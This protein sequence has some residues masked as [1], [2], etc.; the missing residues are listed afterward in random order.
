MRKSPPLIRC[1]VLSGEIYCI[2]RYRVNKT[3][4][5]RAYV[6]AY[7]KFDVTAE[8]MIAV[9]Q[10]KKVLRDMQRRKRR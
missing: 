5:G 10:R 3:R 4:D 2:T 8:A 1:S 6:L 9:A 7:E